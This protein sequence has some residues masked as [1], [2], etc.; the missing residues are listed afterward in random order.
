[1]ARITSTQLE[2]FL[3]F[4]N[5]SIAVCEVKE[6]VRRSQPDDATEDLLAELSGAHEQLRGLFAEGLDNA[7]CVLA[8]DVMELA[9]KST[10]EL[11]QEQQRSGS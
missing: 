1:M 8:R 4:G 6:L 9:S 3:A 11:N 5:A 7:V 2:A 10:A